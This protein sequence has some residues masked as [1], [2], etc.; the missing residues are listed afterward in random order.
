MEVKRCFMWHIEYKGLTL[1]EILI[2][3]YMNLLETSR[4]CHWPRSPVTQN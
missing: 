4:N 2:M 3:A 1:Q